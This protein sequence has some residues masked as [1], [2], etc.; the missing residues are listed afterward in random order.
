MTTDQKLES[1]RRQLDKIGER[2]AAYLQAWEEAKALRPTREEV[3]KVV[4][5]ADQDGVNRS[6]IAER[7]QMSRQNLYRDIG[8]RLGWKAD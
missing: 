1:A 3:L 2:R 5:S 4:E 7:L 8:W 6:E